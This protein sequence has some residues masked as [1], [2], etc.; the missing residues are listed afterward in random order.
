MASLNLGFDSTRDKMHLI[1]CSPIF[2]VESSHEGACEKVNKSRK[3]FGLDD[4]NCGGFE[5]TSASSDRGR[6]E[7]GQGHGQVVSSAFPLLPE[8]NGFL[9]TV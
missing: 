6:A 9:F 3:G 7:S 4:K 8:S 5:L 2:F 1:I